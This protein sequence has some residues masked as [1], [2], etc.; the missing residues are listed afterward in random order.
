MRDE[1]LNGGI[2]Y[3]L[4][5]AQILIERWRQEYN[6]ARP[7]SSLGYRPP[8]PEAIAVMPRD[9]GFAMLRQDLWLDLTPRL[10]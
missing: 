8:T 9:P 3:T 6:M 2:F 10:T 5:E 7:R 1:L 4:Q